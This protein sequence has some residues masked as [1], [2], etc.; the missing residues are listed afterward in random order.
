MLMMGAVYRVFD[1]V[2]R[3]NSELAGL[4]TSTMN[5]NHRNQ[6]YSPRARV[7]SWIEKVMNGSGVVGVVVRATC[8]V[9]AID[10]LRIVCAILSEPSHIALCFRFRVWVFFV[11][12]QNVSMF[13]LCTYTHG[14][15]CS[16]TLTHANIHTPE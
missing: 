14:C 11:L 5:R 13:I 2:H 7:Y 1:C 12:A 4:R 10:L 9:Y 8:I 6:I 15:E 3:S 16:Q